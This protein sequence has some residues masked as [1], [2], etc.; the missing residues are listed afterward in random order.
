ML[1]IYLPYRRTTWRFHDSGGRFAYIIIIVDYIYIFFFIMILK[2]L[3]Y[4][5]DRV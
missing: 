3:Q 4:I 5:Q 1:S 2:I